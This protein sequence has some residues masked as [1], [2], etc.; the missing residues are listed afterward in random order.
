MSC[1]LG[2]IFEYI[3]Y[4]EVNRRVSIITLPDSILFTLDD[5]SRFIPKV[6]ISTGFDVRCG[7]LCET[8]ELSRYVIAELV[9]DIHNHYVEKNRIPNIIYLKN[10][11]TIFFISYSSTNEIIFYKY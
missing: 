1:L 2:S 3:T 8:D 10:N 11:E 6:I 5:T 7:D 9:Y 4:D